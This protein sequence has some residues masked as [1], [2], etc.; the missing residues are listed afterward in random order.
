MATIKD[1]AHK[2]GVSTATVS[3]VLNGTRPVALKTRNAVLQAMSE[4]N[5]MPSAYGRAL[6]T[7]SSRQIGYVVADLINPFFASIFS[8]VQK[9]ALK[10]GYTVVVS[11][12]GEDPQLELDVVNGLLGHGVDGVILAP[13]ASSKICTLASELSVPIV[14]IDRI[15]TQGRIP[16]VTTV[17][18]EAISR[19]VQMIWSRGFHEIAFV[20]G[21]SGLSTTKHRTDAYLNAL[22]QLGLSPRIYHGNSDVNSGRAAAQWIMDCEESLGV[23]CGNNLMAMGFVQ[24]LLDARQLQRFAPGLVIIGD[25]QW[26]TFTSPAL[27]VI[28]QPTVN[29]GVMGT[30]ILID[31]IEGSEQGAEILHL[32]CEFHPR[33]ALPVDQRGQ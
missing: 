7:R 2:A 27:S 31:R 4:L 24:A 5:Y 19:A 28:R 26:T 30:N 32:E 1:V 25:D 6:R 12:S 3:H 33:Q 10:R 11:H 17:M 14:F 13:V 18:A 20:A 21:R 29:I 16:T 9:V 8:G 22:G 23:I 15:C